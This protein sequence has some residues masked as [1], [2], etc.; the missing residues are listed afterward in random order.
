[1]Y[2]KEIIQNIMTG[3]VI[4]NYGVHDRFINYLY[5]PFF[6]KGDTRPKKELG[7]GQKKSVQKSDTSE[8]A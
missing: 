1:M 7:G 8:L 3:D 6:Q 2:A 4:F 5:E